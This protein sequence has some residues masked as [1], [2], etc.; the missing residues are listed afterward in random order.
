MTDKETI[1]ALVAELTKQRNAWDSF[2]QSAEKHG[3][4]GIA[5]GAHTMSLSATL[6]LTTVLL[7]AVPIPLPSTVEPEHPTPGL[8]RRAPLAYETPIPM[9]TA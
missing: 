3:H 6:V 9:G 7:A 2:A 8:A 1:D 5:Q 4:P